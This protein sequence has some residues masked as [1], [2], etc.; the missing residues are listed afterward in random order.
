MAL[1]RYKER[2][3]LMNASIKFLFL[4]WLGLAVSAGVYLFLVLTFEINLLSLA[5]PLRTV[6]QAIGFIIIPIL[7]WVLVLNPNNKRESLLLL[8]G[9]KKGRSL[10]YIL[11]SLLEG[12]LI[13]VVLMFPLFYLGRQWNPLL[14][15]WFD[16][17]QNPR[18]IVYIVGAAVSVT[19]VELITKGYLM[20]TSLE[21]NIPK[22]IIFS[23]SLIAWIF[24]HVVEFLWLSVYVPAWYAIFLLLLAGLL[25]ITSVFNTENIIGV[26]IGHI[27]INVLIF[28]VMNI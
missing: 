12:M 6:V 21:K 15:S 27:M 22:T 26:T 19:S 8:L 11:R 18:I 17:N 23:S 1:Y 5:N 24:G 7:W 14:F 13:Y 9:T 10:R 20:T 2:F 28:I 4:Q 16:A 25:S 3:V